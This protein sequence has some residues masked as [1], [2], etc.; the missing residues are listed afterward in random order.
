[1]PANDLR[2]AFASLPSERRRQVLRKLHKM[3]LTLPDGGAV[4]IQAQQAPKL[5]FD[6][7]ERIRI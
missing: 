3:V 7:L 4:R 6:Q 1:M 5:G 2:A